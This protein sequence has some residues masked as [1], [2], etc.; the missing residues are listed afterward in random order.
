[1]PINLVSKQLVSK[2]TDFEINKELYC[3]NLQKSLVRGALD[4]YKF[5]VDWLIQ[6]LAHR[7]WENFQKWCY[8]GN[9]A[10]NI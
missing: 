8:R 7:F 6:F 2:C 4:L 5:Y 3:I 1:M 9:A 10:S